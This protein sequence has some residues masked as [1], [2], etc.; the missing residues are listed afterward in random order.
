MLLVLLLLQLLL[1][2]LMVMMKQ[3]TLLFFIE[4][5]LVRLVS[6][7]RYNRLMMNQE[8]HVLFTHRLNGLAV[9]VG[10]V[11]LVGVDLPVDVAVGADSPIDDL[12]VE[13]RIEVDHGGLTGLS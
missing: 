7:R 1:L 4:V 8:S 3:Q 10:A 6:R 9:V 13:H 12:T 11:H 2:L 5:L